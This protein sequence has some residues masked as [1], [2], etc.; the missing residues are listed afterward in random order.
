[1]SSGIGGSGNKLLHRRG[2]SLTLTPKNRGNMSS[3]LLGFGGGHRNGKLGLGEPSGSYDSMEM[4]MGGHGHGHN[5]DDR[6][7]NAQL[8]KQLELNK[9]YNELLEKTIN[10]LRHKYNIYNLNKQWIEI[11]KD[12]KPLPS[13]NS[14]TDN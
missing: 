3:D 1:M 8:H 7:V 6:M 4:R 11:K 12:L 2:S 13:F 5:N 9:G 14:M 10:S